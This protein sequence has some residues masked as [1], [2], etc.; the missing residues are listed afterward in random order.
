MRPLLLWQPVTS[1]AGVAIAGITNRGTS[2]AS[3]SRQPPIPTSAAFQT[4]ATP[5]VVTTTA[6]PG[7]VSGLLSLRE[8]ALTRLQAGPNSP[9][10]TFAAEA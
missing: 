1:G 2:V 10:I 4:Q 6:D 3:A 5:F 9:T 7:G 8:A